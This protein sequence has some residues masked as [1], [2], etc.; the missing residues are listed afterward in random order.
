[1]TIQL[2]DRRLLAWRTFLQSH[3]A[4]VEALE[5]ELAAE[6]RLPLS[7]YDV[8]L[9]LYEAP[10]HR[11]RLHELAT[12]V[13]LSR[14]GLTR[15][16]DRLAREGL[17]CRE[18]CST[19]GRGAFAVLTDR[20]LERIGRTW[21][22]YACGIEKHFGSL[23]DDTEVDNLTDSLAR[24]L[25]ALRSQSTPKQPLERGPGSAPTIQPIPEAA[26]SQQP[27]DSS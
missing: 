21:P 23:L 22:I 13:A 17:L 12:S 11:L 1:M 3:A 15:L 9:K 20:G 6:Q 8:L 24:M 25:A 5:R 18:Y 14:S 19:D 7:S 4:L 27:H 26:H 10:G 16:V 2:D